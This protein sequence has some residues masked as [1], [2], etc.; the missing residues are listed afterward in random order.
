M[1]DFT[2]LHLS[3]KTPQENSSKSVNKNSLSRQKT[4]FGAA[5][6]AV[7]VL[8]R[9][10]FNFEGLLMRTQCLTHN[11]MYYYFD[12]RDP[13]AMSFSCRTTI[14]VASLRGYG[15]GG[16]SHPWISQSVVASNIMQ[17]VA[18]RML[19]NSLIA[20]CPGQSHRATDACC[21]VQN[22]LGVYRLDRFA[23]N[24]SPAG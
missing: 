9:A 20:H 22:S 5:L 1:A 3:N 14:S 11:C 24:T 4:L 13:V 21:S 7:T 16:T 18:A 17:V 8:A 19:C 10:C 15:L 2:Q 12:P 23:S 6:L